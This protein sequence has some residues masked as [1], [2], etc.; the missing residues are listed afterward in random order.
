MAARKRKEPSEKIATVSWE[1]PPVYKLSYA[2]DTIAAQLRLHP[3]EW[4]KVF[5]DDRTSVAN[6]IRQG[7]VAAVHPDLGFEIQTTNNVRGPIRTCDMYMRYNPAR[8]GALRQAVYGQR[9]G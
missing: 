3:M 5:S 1:E 9:K 2:W 7:S 6:A 8:V 4:A